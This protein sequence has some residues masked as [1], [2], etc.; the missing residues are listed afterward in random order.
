MYICSE[1]RRDSARM[2]HGIQVVD[3]AAFA[4]RQATVDFDVNNLKITKDGLSIKHEEEVRLEGRTLNKIL[5]NARIKH[6]LVL[7][8]ASEVTARIEKMTNRGWAVHFPV[9]SQ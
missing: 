9:N 3:T 5:R 8:P 4:R 1:L 2:V 7:K 6:L